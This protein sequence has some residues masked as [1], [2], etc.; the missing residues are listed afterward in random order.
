MACEGILYLASYGMQRF[1]ISLKFIFYD[2][3]SMNAKAVFKAIC[4][5]HSQRKFTIHLLIKKPFLKYFI[6]I[7]DRF[8]SFSPSVLE[9][10][11][12]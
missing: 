12:P 9:P 3:A 10:Q 4:R 2:L 5:R 7:L 8:E 6:H 11:V 1:R